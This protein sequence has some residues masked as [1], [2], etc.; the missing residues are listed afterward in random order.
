MNRSPITI[1]DLNTLATRLNATEG[2][3]ERYRLVRVG[4]LQRTWQLEKWTGQRVEPETGKLTRSEMAAY[5]RG[6]IH[7][8]ETIMR[9]IN[10][11][12]RG[13]LHIVARA[14]A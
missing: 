3:R 11:N 12:D 8:A 14:S 2:Y 5:L 7:G 6:R 1:N 4:Q 9:R 13:T 10:R